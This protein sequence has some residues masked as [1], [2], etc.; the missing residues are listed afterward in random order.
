MAR[1]WCVIVSVAVYVPMALAQSAVS[2]THSP[3]TLPSSGPATLPAPAT[4]PV[5]LDIYLLQERH[6]PLVQADKPPCLLGGPG[7]A[8]AVLNLNVPLL[9]RAV[10][11]ANDLLEARLVMKVGQ[12]AGDLSRV[13]VAF[14]RMLRPAGEKLV[15]GEDYEAAPALWLPV[16]EAI[17]EKGFTRIDLAGPLRKYLGGEWPDH[18][19]VMTLASAAGTTAPAATAT[20][21]GRASLRLVGV[22]SPGADFYERTSPRLAI[23]IRRHEN[24]LLFDWPVRPREDTYCTARDGHLWYGGDRLR[25]WGVCR[26]SSHDPLQVRRVARMGFN[27]IRVWGPRDVY[28]AQSAKAGRIDPPA[29]EEYDRYVAAMKRQGM[30]VMSPAF[31]YDPCG[32]SS[33][34]AAVLADDSWLAGGDD[35]SQWKQAVLAKDAPLQFFH[36]FD[37][38]LQRVRRRHAENFLG[39]VNRYTGRPYSREECIAI[40]EVWNENGFL[41]FPWEKGLD[42]W[43]AYFRDKL[44][45]RWNAWLRAR[46]ADQAAVA[47]AW[48]GLGA[49]ES[50]ADGSIALAPMAAAMKDQAARGADLMRFLT[51]L[52]I[53]SNT[54]FRDY[55]RT[56]APAGVGVNVAPFSFD[57]Q[58]RDSRAWLYANSHADVNCIGIYSSQM[59]SN[60][61]KPPHLYMLDCLTLANRPTVVYE[62]NAGHPNPYRTEWIYQVAALAAWQD[63]DAVFFHY[64]QE[65]LWFWKQASPDEQYLIQPLPL[66]YPDADLLIDCDPAMLSAMAAAGQVFRSA[67]LEAA[68]QKAVHRIGGREIFGPWSFRGVNMVQRAFTEGAVAE[69]RPEL[70]EGATVAGQPMGGPETPPKTAVRSGQH[71]LWDWPNARLIID[72][73]TVKAYVGRPAEYRFS[74]GIAVGGF[75]GDFVAFCMVSDDGRPLT[76]AD[77]RGR[78]KITAVRDNNNTGYAIDP[79]MLKRTGFVH[80]NERMKAITDKGQPPLVADVVPYTVTFPSKIDYRFDGYDFALRKCLTV[81]AKQSDTLRHDGRELFM[82]V[83]N[84]R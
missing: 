70:D 57:T 66:K 83:L 55:C 15:P 39:H 27:A 23:T 34:R 17:D 41:L 72:S 33:Q 43:P 7:D 36:Y 10:L 30:F 60:L 82:G 11:G 42:T 68:R 16:K 73:P 25:L 12:Q 6:F 14:H 24:A 19:L 49:G 81:E 26:Q 84:R 62:T 18:G 31:M 13:H 80:P 44:R 2:A 50:L 8:K 47:R 37:E 48:G 9:R 35:W 61:D 54:E 3:A 67:G 45:L 21:G 32:L 64:F 53:R 71:I 77:A 56:L 40:F 76:G 20:A 78:I 58:Y 65:P 63:W 38:R 28:T 79:A 29:M 52:V 46:Y 5:K 1:L 74:D 22:S 75:A 59:N 4:G 51:E 69:F